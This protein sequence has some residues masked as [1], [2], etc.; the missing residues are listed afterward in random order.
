MLALLAAA[1]GYL[2]FQA[3]AFLVPG[4]EELNKYVVTGDVKQW[5]DRTGSLQATT[6]TAVVAVVGSF[7]LFAAGAIFSIAGLAPK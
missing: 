4:P 3:N 5:R 7:L 6:I 1:M 2:N